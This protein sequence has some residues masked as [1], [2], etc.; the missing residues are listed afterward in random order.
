MSIIW[1]DIGKNK[2]NYASIINSQKQI[3]QNL[4]NNQL[5]EIANKLE[6]VYNNIIYSSQSLNKESAYSQ[7]INNLSND[8][9]ARFNSYNVGLKTYRKISSEKTHKNLE[10]MKKEITTA[11]KVLNM[12]AKKGAEATEV[13]HNLTQLYKLVNSFEGNKK[14][15]LK[16]PNFQ[17]NYNK[18]VV[19]FLNQSYR[20]KVG[21]NFENIIN[22]I[23]QQSENFAEKTVSKIIG[24][25]TS[26]SQAFI[27][28]QGLTQQA[29]SQLQEQNYILDE[30]GGK[31][32]Y[33]MRTADKADISLS[34][35]DGN[36]FLSLK[37]YINPDKE[38][39]ISGSTKLATLLSS[40]KVLTNFSTAFLETIWYGGIDK[41][42]GYAKNIHEIGKYVV[43]TLMLTGAGFQNT[44][45]NILVVNNRSMRR[46][47][48]FSM[49]DIVNKIEKNNE[50]LEI[51][52][53]PEI[54][55]LQESKGISTFQVNFLNINVEGKLKNLIT[56]MGK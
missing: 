14:D 25:A 21:Q 16:H 42:K 1:S 24:D 18:S 13:R 12:W 56:I 34:I 26:G 33:K 48:C 53:F 4:K 8:L 10:T 47:Y 3:L 30:K 31:L 27:S 28:S 29:I 49:A 50:L 6:M 15:L 39:G 22:A 2:V 17:D 43:G 51:K 20:Q 55:S 7:I 19:E 54:A 11:L 32:V 38:I 23:N 35:G 37:N 45:A 41:N 44:A 52:N 5:K 40:N 46:I 9:D 36:Y